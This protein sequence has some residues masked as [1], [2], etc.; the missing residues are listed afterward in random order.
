MASLQ[1]LHYFLD[2]HIF[3]QIVTQVEGFDSEDPERFHSCVQVLDSLVGEVQVQDF[4]L[5]F[6][7]GVIQQ[8]LVVDNVVSVRFPFYLLDVVGREVVAELEDALSE[9][10]VELEHFDQRE[11]AD[12][13]YFVPCDLQ[14][15]DCVVEPESLAQPLQSLIAYFVSPQVYHFKGTLH[16]LQEHRQDVAV[17]V[18]HLLVLE[19][20]DLGLAHK[21]QVLHGCTEL[22]QILYV[23]VLFFQKFIFLSFSLAALQGSFYLFEVFIEVYL[24]L[25]S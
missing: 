17:L 23:E 16:A 4:F 20:Q 14:V 5:V 10:V 22:A 25:D 19:F 7:V 24:R 11:K 8:D 15:G 2:G 1:S 3:K 12:I 13:G 6:F 18:R 9:D 21:H